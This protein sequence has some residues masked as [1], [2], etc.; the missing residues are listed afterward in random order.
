MTF[1]SSNEDKTFYI[2]RPRTDSVEGLM[3]LLFY[4][5]QTHR[6]CGK[7]QLCSRCRF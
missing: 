1:G 2:I 5:I 7:K 4:V 6:V 3:A